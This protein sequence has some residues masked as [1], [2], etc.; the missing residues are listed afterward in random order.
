MASAGKSTLLLLSLMWICSCSV[1]KTEDGSPFF[2][3]KNECPKFKEDYNS[4]AYEI[5]TYEPSKWVST[6]IT[7][8]N[9]L[10]AAEEGFDRLFAYIQ[11]ENVQHKKIPMTV[12]VIN[13][14]IPGTG[15]VCATKFTFSF[16]VP[17][18][19]QKNTPKPTSPDLFLSELPEQKVYVRV[20]PGFTSQKRFIEEAQELAAAL[21]S[22]QTY[23]KSMYYLAGYDSPFHLFNRHNEIW[24]I[25]TKK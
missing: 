2:C 3:R 12:P 9:Y 21:N 6:T 17:F 4:T 18:E 23:D 10:E 15:P 13:T 16:F 24:F 25:A 11:G 19:F 8:I 5:R 22:T 14:V 1:I 20:Y 7:G